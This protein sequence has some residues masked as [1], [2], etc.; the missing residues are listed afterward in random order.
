[1]REFPESVLYEAEIIAHNLC[2][3][4]FFA[5]R[6]SNGDHTEEQIQEIAALFYEYKELMELTQEELEQEI[7][8][9]WS[10]NPTDLMTAIKKE[11][12]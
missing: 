10:I 12:E 4:L 2:E 5:E 11:I 9:V 1:M 6:S 7:N 8:E 3:L